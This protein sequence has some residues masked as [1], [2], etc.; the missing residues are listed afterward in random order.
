MD[1]TTASQI[2]TASQ[3]SRLDDIYNVLCYLLVIGILLLAALFIKWVYYQF[4]SLF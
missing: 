3:L 2:M 4:N 1:V